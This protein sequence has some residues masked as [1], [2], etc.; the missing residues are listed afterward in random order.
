MSID[1]KSLSVLINSI[2][3]LGA[4]ICVL[5][6]MSGLAMV[7]RS[8]LNTEDAEAALS[9]LSSIVVP[10]GDTIARELNGNFVNMTVRTTGGLLLSTVID[11][12]PKVVLTS[13]C[14]ENL[15]STITH[16]MHRLIP[17]ISNAMEGIAVE[18]KDRQT[19]VSPDK[20]KITIFFDSFLSK[21]DKAV[22]SQDLISLLKSTKEDLFTLVPAGTISYEMNRVVTKLQKDM[23]RLNSNPEYILK[24]KQE[25]VTLVNGW[26]KRLLE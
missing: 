20:R 17:I 12:D 14:D 2:V 18:I 22:T 16:G 11:T 25:L 10:T 3:D 7:T 19:G 1:V 13:V 26:K 5:S 8:N 21:V 23:S 24:V 4:K 15:E 6:D 9:A